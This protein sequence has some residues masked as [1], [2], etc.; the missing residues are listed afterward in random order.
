MEIPHPEEDL[1]MY[2]RNRMNK[3]IFTWTLISFV[4]M[5]LSAQQPLAG[6]D[7]L[8]RTLLQNNAVGD[9]KS[10]RQIAMFYFL[11]HGDKV[12]LTSERYWDLDEISREHPEVFNDRN[13][14]YWGSPPGRYY[15][16]GKPIYGYYHGDDY[17]VHL[18]NIQ[19]L[20]DAG[21]DLLIIDATNR[22]TY[23]SQSEALMKAM[24]NVRAQGKNPPKIVYYTNSA[25]GETMQEIYNYY[26]REGA[27]H[28]HPECWFYLYGKPLIIG[29]TSEIGNGDYKD[30]FT[31]RES[32]WPT[33]SKVANGWPWISFKRKPEV[34]FNDRGEKEI[35]N[36]STAQHPNPSIGMGGS[37][38]YGNK[39]NWGRSFRNNSPGN[40][41]IDLPYGY[42]FQEQWDYA[43]QENT[44]FIFVTGW[45]EWIAGRWTDPHE[46][47][48]VSFFC[49]QASP[50]YSRDIEPTLTG[51]LKDH[52]YMQLI[53][54]IRKYKGIE[55]EQPA[56]VMQ[57]IKKNG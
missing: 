19:L 12:S 47:P 31:F 22:L 27:P 9:P 20:T 5:G 15:F 40:S 21:V 45:N 24:D 44:P 34:H 46:N 51:D 28:R 36:V 48:N 52:Y 37:A 10:N 18:K 4:H 42:N 3:L 23:P 7:E 16:W 41:E 13:N 2:M 25:S 57:S 26:Y 54:N 11:W 6:T 50:E 43:L 30:F 38:F 56:G 35:L 49:D 53:N 17:W 29:V 39:E 1:I 8:G 14:P 32:Q 33:V 55:K